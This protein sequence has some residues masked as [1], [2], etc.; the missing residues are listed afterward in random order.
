MY[1][2]HATTPMKK[3]ESQILDLLRADHLICGDAVSVTPLRGG[4]SSDV[5][6]IE[7]GEN[8]F[9][10]KRALPQ[11]KVRDLWRADTSRNRHEFNYLKYVNGILPASVPV[12]FVL[13]PDYF[14]M[15]YLGPEFKNWKQLLLKGD[16]QAEH[17]RESARIL[18]TVHRKSMNDAAARRSFDTTAN[19][20]QLRTDPYLLTTGRRHPALRAYFEEEARRLESTRECLVH[21]DY[22]PKNIL[23][24]NGRIVVLDCEVAWYG[25]SAFDLA[26]LLNHLLLKSLY[27]M[28]RDPGFREL[29]DTAIAQYYCERQLAEKLQCE[30]DSRT[31]KLVLLLLLARID[32]KSPVEYLTGENKREFVRSFVTA[33]LRANLATLSSL[34]DNWFRSLHERYRAVRN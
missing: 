1:N 2:V 22:S 10:L 16:C 18:A 6:L 12:P 24:R 8:Q 17:A 21:G 19:F 11:L 30:L 7:D 32:G 13:G 9:V 4:V 3:R 26:F 33:G 5:Y 14:T 34:A 20:H 27:H 15:E 23:V 29:I 31:A 28:P 25:D